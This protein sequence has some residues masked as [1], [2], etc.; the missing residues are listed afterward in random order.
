MKL[1]ALP[2]TSNVAPW[3]GQRYPDDTLTKLTAQHWCVQ[4][5][6]TA[7][8]FP[9]AWQTTMIWLEKQLGSL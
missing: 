3:Q 8:Y 9:A 5:D 2:V 1:V 6:E 7:T 4:P